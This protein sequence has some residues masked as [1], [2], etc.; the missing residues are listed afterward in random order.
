MHCHKFFYATFKKGEA[1]KM[2]LSSGSMIVTRL[3]SVHQL[4]KDH[5]ILP[6]ILAFW[7]SLVQTLVFCRVLYSIQHYINLYPAVSFY[8]CLLLR[9][10]G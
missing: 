10:T 1:E 7:Y 4:S 8:T 5:N 9:M 2:T 3:T 6:S